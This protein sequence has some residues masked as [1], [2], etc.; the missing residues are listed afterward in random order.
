[1]TESRR[2]ENLPKMTITAGK[3]PPGISGLANPDITYPGIKE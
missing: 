2:L 1:L 3:E